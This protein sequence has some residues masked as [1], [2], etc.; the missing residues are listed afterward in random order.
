[1][2]IFF[3][4]SSVN[5]IYLGALF[6]TIISFVQQSPNQLR[7]LPDVYILGSVR[8]EDI[9]LIA[10][11]SD[12]EFFEIRLDSELAQSMWEKLTR[13]SQ[14]NW[15]YWREPFEQSD[16]LMLEYVHLL[17]QGKRLAAVIDEQIRQRERERRHDELAII[18][19][20]AVLCAFGGEVEAKRLFEL[21]QLPPDCAA[22]ALK[23]LIDE[24]LVR[25]SRPGVLGGLHALRS[26]ALCDASHDD[27]SYLRSDS[28]WQ[29]LAASTN[30]TLPR[31]IQSV[32]NETQNGAEAVTIQNLAKALAASD[33]IDVWAAIFTG[34]GIGT[35]E[36]SVAS[37]MEMLEKHGVQRSHWFL[38]SMFSDASIDVPEL[39][40]FEN[41]KPMRNAVIAFRALPKR[42]LRAE[43]LQ[44]LPEGT[45]APVCP[46]I[47]QAN[48]LLSSLVPIA[49]GDPI[50]I[51]FAPDFSSYGE[52]NIH[53]VAALLSTAYL[54]EPDLAKDFVAAFGGEQT[55]FTWFHS[56]IPWVTVPIIEP[57]G[58]QGRTV[59]ANRFFVAES[60][61][62]DAHKTLCDICETLIAISPM[63][64]AAASDAIGLS[65]QPI[66]INGL[67]DWSKN[68]PRENLPSKAR[69]A[70]NVAFRQILLARA[71]EHSLTDY[72]H[73]MAD[74]VRQTEKVFRLFSEQW[75]KGWRISNKDRLASEINEIVD[76]VDDL[77]YAK[78]KTLASSMTSTTGDT[79]EDDR[80]GALLTSVL[81]NL[82][83]RMCKI[84]PESDAKAAAAFT[85]GLAAQAREHGISE[86]WRTTPSPPLD[87][88]AVLAE[89]LDGVA[90]VLH[91]IAHDDTARAIKNL[92]KA[93][94]KGRMGKAI[95]SAAGR[96]RLLAKARF[97]RRLRAL[98]NALKAQGLT[99]RCRTRPVN[100]ADSIDWPAVEVAILIKITDS[101]TDWDYLE[102]G[103]AIG[104]KQ[105]AQDWRFYVVP[106]IN[107]QVIADLAFISLSQGP[108]LDVEFAHKWKAHINLPFLSSEVSNAF[109]IAVAACTQISAIIRYR[110]LKTLHPAEEEALLK[111]IDDFEC[112]RKTVD[113]FQ[114]KTGLELFDEA[115]VY[116]DER[117]DQIVSEIESMKTGQMVDNP[118]CHVM[119]DIK[120]EKVI[121][122][123]VARMLLRQAECC[124]V[125]AD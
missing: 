83:P 46:D 102:Y 118:L 103:L 79:E 54:I 62:T 113:A 70:W 16:G 25:E 124:T 55:L 29:S 116:L 72:T 87:E 49:G 77:I 3:D 74:H 76:H 68:I 58:T 61:Q 11:Q 6:F 122:L 59:R 57:Q 23:R 51:S 69:V 4:T 105:L 75:I 53:D 81:D 85:S 43:C 66:E 115:L 15:T 93:A 64:D 44:M 5:P 28:L 92:R 73:E 32:L 20:T 56:Q 7:S 17:T 52:Q 22:Q 47:R 125:A 65:G 19:S 38:A 67:S 1:M 106:V 2:D 109:D 94:R 35:M 18:R 80:L 14:T 50:Q 111:A 89:R 120:N 88:L 110:D 60:H 121:E 82:V 108:L 123:G 41:L 26:K 40:G 8:N 10:N 37:F 9:G 97:H 86:I 91:E 30:E 39:S 34:L 21:L 48:L 63:S 119:G 99:A 107:N 100:D 95:H 27:V 96:C 31:I 45:Q 117:W 42:D 84:P 98:E 33:N 36:K 71:A 78:P 112:N 90:C 101:E 12:T 13:Q 114:K 24:H 104:K